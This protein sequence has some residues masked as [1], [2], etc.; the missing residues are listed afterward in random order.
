MADKFVEANS[1]AEILEVQSEPEQSRIGPPA[2]IDHRF[3]ALRSPPDTDKLKLGCNSRKRIYEGLKFARGHLLGRDPAHQWP[4]YVRGQERDTP[5][6]G[7][8][9]FAKTVGVTSPRILSLG[10]AFL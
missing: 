10:Y 7:R 6:R 3:S 4:G 2:P 9:P 1:R 5:A 8:A